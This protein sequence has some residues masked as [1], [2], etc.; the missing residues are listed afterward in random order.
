MLICALLHRVLRGVGFWT[1]VENCILH[2]TIL[3]DRDSVY[4][5]NSACLGQFGVTEPF[6]QMERSAT[7]TLY[8]VG[9]SA[10][11]TQLTGA[12]ISPAA[13]SIE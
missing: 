11:V 2:I 4:K 1:A 13:S 8:W 10:N 12:P 9:A 7:A 6:D 3:S 5:T